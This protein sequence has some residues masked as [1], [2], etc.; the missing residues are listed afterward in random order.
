ML[1]SGSVRRHVTVSV[2]QSGLLLM[3][4][5][6]FALAIWITLVHRRRVEASER[7]TSHH[8]AEVSGFVGGFAKATVDLESTVMEAAAALGPLVRGHWVRLSQA[9]SPAMTVQ[10]D[11][12]VLATA[13]RE[14]MMTAVRATPGG[15]VLVT[16]ASLGR[17]L[18]ICITDDGRGDDQRLRESL[19]REAGASIALQ[20]GSVVVQAMPGR[21][22]IV[23]IRLPLPG[24]ESEEIDDLEKFPALADQAA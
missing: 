4:G 6:P 1:C 16:A 12:N 19:V 22:T 9:V 13:L 7:S 23:T 5:T 24:G 20:G 2:V 3:P 11:P 17:Q 8:V 15:Q 14:T 18:H 10:V 21:G